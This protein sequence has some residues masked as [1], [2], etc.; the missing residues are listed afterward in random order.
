MS[1]PIG[2]S[3]HDD[4]SSPIT[5]PL[6][7]NTDDARH[8]GWLGGSSRA[9]LNVVR[10][11]D[12]PEF[13]VKPISVGGIFIDQVLDDQPL[14]KA[15]IQTADIIVRVDE[16]WLPVKTEPTQ[17]FIELIENANTAKTGSV[18]LLVLRDSR[19]TKIELT[20]DQKPIDDGLPL[21]S[22]RFIDLTKFALDYL[23]SRQ[24]LDGSFP[25]QRNEWNA[26]R[27]S[28]SLAGLAFLS[29]APSIAD[30]YKSNI[31]DCLSFISKSFSDTQSRPVDPLTI[32]YVVQF[33][34]ESDIQFIEANWLDVIGALTEQLTDQQNESGAWAI[35]AES[36][37]DTP[38]ASNE[39]DIAGT[40]I[41]NQV[42]LAIGALERKGFEPDAHVIEKA[43][44]FLQSQSIMRTPSDIDRRIKA[45]LSAGTAAALIAINCDRNSEPLGLY[46]QEVSDRFS[47]VHSSPALNWPGFLHVAILARQNNNE[48]WLKFHDATKY[49]SVQR[50]QMDGKVVDLPGN[51]SKLLDFETW[52]DSQVWRNAH[53]AIALSLQS[54]SLEKSLALTASEPIKTRDHLGKLFNRPAEDVADSERAKK[55]AELTKM[56]LEQ[57]KE[58]GMDVDENDL[59]KNPPK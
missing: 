13:T 58:S 26:K 12:Q 25:T 14:A 22:D 40:F 39:I 46:V 27:I 44:Q 45:V 9:L 35:R 34:A 1:I 4:S 19:L 48:T 55:A 33:F 50:I 11:D 42:L 3:T 8:L 51:G 17:D 10:I 23:A 43:C 16:T 6:V 49:I 47:D 37:L 20:V 5:L 28:T 59:K 18:E 29:A 56:I 57:L 30:N 32:A 53:F 7:S 52:V 54:R 24:N 31:G 36:S 38:P 21:A 2:C 15:G 41:T